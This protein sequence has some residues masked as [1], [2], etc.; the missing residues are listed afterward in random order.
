[1]AAPIVAF[2]PRAEVPPLGDQAIHL[3]SH[4]VRAAHTPRMIAE[5]ARRV[6][7]HLLRVYA[8]TD[9]VPTIERGPHGK[10]FLPALPELGFNLS[11]A[12]PH[13]LLAFAR[14]QA[15]GVDIEQH[16]RRV[17]ID[18]IAER[19][20]TCDE[21]S[22]LRQLAPDDKMPG[23]LRLWTHKEALLKALGQGLSFGLDR[24]EFAFEEG[25]NV[26]RLRRIPAEAGVLSTWNLS[27]L[28]PARELI[29]ALAWYG[30]PRTV[31]AFELIS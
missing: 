11:H 21:A 28:A 15:L 26:M 10:P 18:D 7:Q 14:G 4:T 25:D 31:R 5:E 12:G 13:V 2:E 24:V 1:M 3:W 8:G 19:Y 23:F 16:D 29:G 27:G 20:F 30:P 9:P 22:A 17:S 6:L